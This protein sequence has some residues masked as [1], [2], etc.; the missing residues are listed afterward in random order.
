MQGRMKKVFLVAE[1]PKRREI[2]SEGDEVEDA[3]LAVAAES[4]VVPK[5]ASR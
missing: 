2:E 5:A 3:M 1:T 4:S